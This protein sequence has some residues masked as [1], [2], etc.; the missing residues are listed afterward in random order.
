MPGPPPVLEAALFRAAMRLPL[1]VLRRLAGRPVVLDGQ[2]L[3]PE[4]QWML[5]L[6]RVAREPASESLP[7]PEGRRALRRQTALVGGRQPVGETRDLEVP[8][9]A[10]GLRARLYVPRVEVG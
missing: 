9:P 7:I 4:T 3:H 1:P 5:R 6:E 2:V 10:G 8:T